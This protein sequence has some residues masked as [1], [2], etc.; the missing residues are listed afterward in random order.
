MQLSELELFT[1]NAEAYSKAVI[2]YQALGFVI[3]ERGADSISLHLF[4][5]REHILDCT[6]KLKL[7]QNL[8][9]PIIGKATVTYCVESLEVSLH[10]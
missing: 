2:F 6:I 10:C 9:N 4:S 8:V 7:I 3:L 1:N 5:V